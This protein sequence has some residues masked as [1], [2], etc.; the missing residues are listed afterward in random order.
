MTKEP[1]FGAAGA[2]LGPG[3][4]GTGAARQFPD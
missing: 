1:R 2:G 3:A 4:A